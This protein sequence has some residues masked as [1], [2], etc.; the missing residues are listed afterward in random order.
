V[1]F[2]IAAITFIVWYFLVPE[3]LLSRAL[4]NFVSV[5]IIACPCAM[6]LATPTA[7]MVGTGVGAEKGILIKG[8]ES[9]ENACKIT[10][11][12]FDKT[13]PTGRHGRRR[14]QLTLKQVSS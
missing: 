10:T 8:G 11:V 14:R 12:V 6:G 7:V 2:G 1:V 5:L 9:L 3:P 4:L 13:D